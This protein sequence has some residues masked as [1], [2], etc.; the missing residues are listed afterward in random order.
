MSRRYSALPSAR[1]V[2]RSG[3]PEAVIA[4][5]SHSG[6]NVRLDAR[7]H[8]GGRLTNGEDDLPLL[9]TRRRDGG[10]RTGASQV[11]A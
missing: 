2:A 7:P 6:Y 9:G 11:E 8:N 3:L 1:L 5:P 10:L 4:I